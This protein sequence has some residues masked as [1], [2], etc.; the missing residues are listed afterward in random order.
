[1]T[2]KGGF[3]LQVGAFSQVEGA[4][5]RADVLVKA[6]YDARVETSYSGGTELNTVLVGNFKDRESAERMKSILKKDQG[7]DSFILTK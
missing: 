2:P 5:N 4:N 6:G 7:M 3:S 1:M